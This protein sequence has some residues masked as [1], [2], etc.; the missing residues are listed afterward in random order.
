MCIP[1]QAGDYYNKSLTNGVHDLH[2]VSGETG[3][4]DAGL[5]L[6][7]DPEDVLLV[8]HHVVQSDGAVV[9]TAHHGRLPLHGRPIT[10]LDDVG[11]DLRTAIVCGRLPV[12]GSAEPVHHTDHDFLW[13][14]GHVWGEETKTPSDR[15]LELITLSDQSMGTLIDYTVLLRPFMLDIM[16]S[17]EISCKHMIVECFHLN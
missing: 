8:L 6:R 2:W 16:E 12:D 5:V 14:V 17:M 9:S 11:G 10:E 7:P 1:C 13:C 4:A 15:D 3:P